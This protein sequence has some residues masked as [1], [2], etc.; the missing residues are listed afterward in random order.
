M[1]SH[2][3][4]RKRRLTRE[5]TQKEFDLC[6]KTPNDR[7]SARGQRQHRGRRRAPETP[8]DPAGAVPARPFVPG[9]LI[10]LHLADRGGGTDALG[11]GA[12]EALPEARSLGRVSGDRTGPP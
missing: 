5:P 12:A 3:V 2:V 10:R 9:S 6:P 4:M 1:R 11:E 8:P 7:A